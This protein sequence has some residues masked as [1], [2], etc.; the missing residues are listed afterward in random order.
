[1]DQIHAHLAGLIAAK[2]R[3]GALQEAGIDALANL[4]QLVPG[5]NVPASIASAFR[6]AAG[7]AGKLKLSH[8]LRRGAVLAIDEQA[9][10][11]KKIEDMLVRYFAALNNPADRNLP[12]VPAI[13]AID[14][15]QWAD[16]RSLAFTQRLLQQ[17]TDRGWH[18][19][20]I[21][22]ART[23]ELAAQR[24][25]GE[26]DPHCPPATALRLES[27]LA[28]L[29]GREAVVLI[30]LPSVLTKASEQ[31]VLRDHLPGATQQTI[32]ALAERSAGH[33]FYL[34]NYARYVRERDWLDKDGNLAVSEQE[35]RTLPRKV[36]ALIDAR[37][38]LLGN[39]Q[40]DVLKWGSVQ[41]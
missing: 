24:D 36:T 25:H 5:L 14:D 39:L 32:E 15:L 18:L 29:L 9:R 41:G 40:L 10:E 30:D 28:R 13:I 7:F 38:E 31:Q 34:V 26:D 3:Q 1:M 2:L 19:L 11:S 16:A 17:A 35:L 21:A 20:L 8:E 4:A 22:T 12:T 27:N 23:T 37:L 6:D 33:P